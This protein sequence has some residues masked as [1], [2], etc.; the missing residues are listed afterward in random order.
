MLEMSEDER[1][2]K[3]PEWIRKKVSVT[4]TRREI[5]VISCAW[6]EVSHRYWA[7][8]TG[9][10]I[11]GK[12]QDAFDRQLEASFDVK[13]NLNLEIGIIILTLSILQKFI[14]DPPAELCA[15]CGEKSKNEPIF[16]QTT[17]EIARET[18]KHLTAIIREVTGD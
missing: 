18:G 5:D 10:Y 14:E 1:K 16:S 3:Q 17:L 8:E 2:T 4:L 15:C 9:V 13:E 11:R 7:S 6:N 12:F